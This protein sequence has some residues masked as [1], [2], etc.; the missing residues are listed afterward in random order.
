MPALSE[1]CNRPEEYDS[2]H[3]VDW[4]IGAAMLIRREC[5]DALNG[6][7]PS[8]FLFS[9]EVDFCLRARDAGWQTWYEA[10]AVV[11]HIG[12]HSGWDENLHAIEVVNRV[13]LYRR[14]HGVVSSATYWFLELGAESFNVVRGDKIHR[15]AVVSLLRPSRRPPQLTAPGYRH[16]LPQ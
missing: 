6:W 13:R 16:L 11:E 1:S 15:Y 4:A 14:R 9:E 5:F 10:S 3:A 2:S 7:E 12:K 8:F